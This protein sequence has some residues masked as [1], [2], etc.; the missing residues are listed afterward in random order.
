MKKRLFYIYGILSYL[1]CL[2]VFLYLIGFMANVVVPKSIDS[3]PP[4]PLML[5]LLI[6]TGLI[7]LFALQHSVMA[8]QGFK[9]WWTKVVPKPIERSTYVLFASIALALMMWLW[10]PLPQTIWSIE[11][12][13]ANILLWTLFGFGWIF[14]FIS[15]RLINE[16]HLFGLQQVR[17][18]L[19][20]KKLSDPK[21]QTPAFY[22]VTRHPMMLG[23]IIAFWVTPQ[24][25]VGHL[26][27]ALVST[28]Y[29]VIGVQLEERDLLHFIGDQYWEY[30]Q[31]VAMLIPGLK[32]NTLVKNNI[33]PGNDPL[34][35]NE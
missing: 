10:Q 32:Y 7:T 26:L 9:R 22:R 34:T 15:S 4:E 1:I 17:E 13:P 5:S 30:R 24:M 14:L 3:G 23:F 29:I 12:Q 33:E 8:R 27:F 16:K 2:G 18:Y 21:F 11:S 28:L 31:R 20:G 6:N 19:Q 25:S 35:E